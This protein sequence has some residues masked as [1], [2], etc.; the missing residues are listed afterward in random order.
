MTATG[1]KQETG[2]Q[3]QAWIDKLQQL[4]PGKIM[5][6]QIHAL[7]AAQFE[8]FFVLSDGQLAKAR[9][10]RTVADDKP[11]YLCRVSLADAEI[12]ETIMLLNFMHQPADSPFQ[13]TH[14]IFVRENARQAFPD[15]G[16]VPEVLQSRLISA[17]AFDDRHFMVDADV[18]DGAFLSKSIPA[19]LQDSRVVYLQ[20]HN[21]KL[22]CFLACATRS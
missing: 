21:A 1:R 20:L 22:G 16:V 17:R 8:S 2:G 14:A 5:S 9:A 10:R 15:V 18:V 3:Q 6:F 12:G 19:M 7:P 4:P 11:G 13:A